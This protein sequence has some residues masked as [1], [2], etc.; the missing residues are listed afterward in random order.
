[1]ESRGGLYA[2]NIGETGRPCTTSESGTGLG[3][4]RTEVTIGK[5]VHELTSVDCKSSRELVVSPKAKAE[6][7]LG[8]TEKNSVVSKE[9]EWET[10]RPKN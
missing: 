5:V 1:M 4:C 8:K 9:V 10:E 2:P 7:T 6:E 3:T